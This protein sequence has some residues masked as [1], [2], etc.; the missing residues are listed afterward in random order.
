MAPR[1]ALGRIH[2]VRARSAAAL[3][4]ILQ[5]PADRGTLLDRTATSPGPPASY[6]RYASYSDISDRV[7]IDTNM[8]ATSIPPYDVSIVRIEPTATWRTARAH[9]HQY[10]ATVFFWKSTIH[11]R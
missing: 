7:Q 2:R 10:W 4:P 1:A 8:N 5:P 3:R 6:C 11:D 9:I